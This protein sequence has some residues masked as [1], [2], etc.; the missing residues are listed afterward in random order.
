MPEYKKLPQNHSANVCV[1]EFEMKHAHRQQ[2]FWLKTCFTQFLCFYDTIHHMHSY[3]HSRTHTH[4]C[5]RSYT[6]ERTTSCA[7]YSQST[8][9]YQNKKKPKW[10]TSGVFMHL[11]RSRCS[12]LHKQVLFLDSVFAITV[13]SYIPWTPY[14]SFIHLS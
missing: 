6:N 12:F 9:F 11:F 7:Q 1:C 8:L 4:T 5:T 13:D 10:Y 14:H 2:P 3:S